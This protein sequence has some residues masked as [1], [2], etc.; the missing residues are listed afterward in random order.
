MSA[1]K[2]FLMA[3]AATLALMAMAPPATAGWRGLNIL[4]YDG[5]G[6]KCTNAME[7]SLANFSS[8]LNVRVVDVTPVPEVE[9]VPLTPLTLLFAPVP[10]LFDGQGFGTGEPYVFSRS[11]RLT[12]SPQPQAGDE[13]SVEFSGGSGSNGSTAE[14]V[15]GCTLG[16]PFA[17]FLGKVKNPPTLN[18]PKPGKP[19]ELKFSLPGNHGLDIF[20]TDEGPTFAPIPCSPQA[21]TPEY[22]PFTAAGSLS[23]HAGSDRYAFTWQPPTGLT[24]CYEFWFRT[25]TDGLRHPALFNFG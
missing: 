3:V 14:F 1:R 6:H 17:G 10:E 19:I 5:G 16:A 22:Q 11:F 7:F 23:Y 12:F 15:E 2:I 8:S 13:L 18:V 21:T 25:T 9:V 24:G 4:N 20:A